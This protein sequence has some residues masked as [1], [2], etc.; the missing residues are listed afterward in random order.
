MRHLLRG[1]L[2]IRL[3]RN[4]V[5]FAE[6]ET[7]VLAVVFAHGTADIT[8][9]ANFAP[10]MLSPVFTA[11]ETLFGQE[12][13]SVEIALLLPFDTSLLEI[14]PARRFVDVACQA[15]NVVHGFYLLNQFWVWNSCDTATKKTEFLSY[16]VAGK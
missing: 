1:W 12:T 6:Y 10:Q 8:A 4:G 16:C 13:Q 7:A 11:V 9:E 5:E 14:A 3:R 2:M 15:L